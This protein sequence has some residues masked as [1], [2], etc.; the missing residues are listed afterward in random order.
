VVVLNKCVLQFWQDF[1]VSHEI[2]KKKYYLIFIDCIHQI[3]KTENPIVKSIKMIDFD[4]FNIYLY[5][6]NSSFCLESGYLSEKSIVSETLLQLQKNKVKVI[7]FSD[8]QRRRL[9]ESLTKK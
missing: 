2:K 8:S 7:L 9:S 5:L 4:Y 6:S 3:Y 1:G